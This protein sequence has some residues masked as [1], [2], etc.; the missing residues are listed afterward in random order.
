MPA[1]KARRQTTATTDLAGWHRPLGTLA[2][3]DA[4]GRRRRSETCRRRREADMASASLA[5]TTCTAAAGQHRRGEHVA[6]DRRQIRDAAELAGP[7]ASRSRAELRAHPLQ[8]RAI[9][10]PT[11]PLRMPAAAR[12]RCR[13]RLRD[14]A[15]P[16]VRG[17]AREPRA[18]CLASIAR[19][20]SSIEEHRHVA[21]NAPLA[22]GFA[23]PQRRKG[24]G[25]IGVA[26]EQAVARSTV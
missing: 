9:S 3:V 13:S 8:L 14:E 24:V 25:Q 7:C 2:R 10:S 4:R 5:S 12:P 22:A 1:A 6:P 17:R 20:R 11:S 18:G 19:R 26:R 23:A 15:R 16:R 21:V